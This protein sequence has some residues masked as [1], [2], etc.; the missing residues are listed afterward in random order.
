ML[1]NIGYDFITRE[2]PNV[3]TFV[4][5][6]VDILLEEDIVNRYYGEDG[7]DLVHLGRLIKED[8]YKASSQDKFLGRVLRISKSKFKQMNGFPNTFY[9][10]GGEDDALLHR[11]ENALVY[12]PDEPVTGVE[13]ETRNDIFQNKDGRVESNKIEQL[14]LDGIQWKIDGVN[15]LQYTIEDNVVINERVRKLTVQLNPSQHRSTIDTIPLTV[16]DDTQDGG[17]A[18]LDE[19]EPEVDETENLDV[20]TENLDVETVPT[21]DL[22]ILNIAEGGTLNKSENIHKI[23]I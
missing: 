17:T 16:Y 13:M 21:D 11:I 1:L 20:E 7:H 3:N 2:L 23:E 8:K 22:E 10:W 5:H 6:D 15:S 19:Y 18:Q 9:G 12:R 14:I 4:V